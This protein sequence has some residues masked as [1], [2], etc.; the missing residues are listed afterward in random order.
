MLFFFECDLSTF[1]KKNNNQKSSS[2]HVFKFTCD[3]SRQKMTSVRHAYHA[4]YAKPRYKV[5]LHFFSF[6][7]CISYRIWLKSVVFSL[8]PII[9]IK[10]TSDCHGGRISPLTSS[11]GP[12]WSFLTNDPV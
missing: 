5:I 4:N 8:L 7:R 10:C 1:I 9:V 2:N 3:V 11:L 12:D 6:K